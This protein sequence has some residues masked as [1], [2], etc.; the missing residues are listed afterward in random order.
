MRIL[1]ILDHSI[2]LHTGYAL[3]TQMILRAQ[4][5]LGWETF[6]LSG[7]K[8]GA[9]AADH[10]TVDGWD[11]HRTVPPGGLFEGVA[12]LSE[13]EL[14]GEIAHRIEQIVKKVRPHILH[15]HSPVLNAIPA[16]RVGRR[17]NIPVVYEVRAIWE[18]A[19]VARGTSRAG[20][21]FYRLRRA[22]ETWA[23]KRADAVT[24]LCEGLR[25]DIVA[26]GIP[27]AKV[28]VVP[29]AIETAEFPAERV[30][31]PVLK[32]Q[33]GIDGFPVLGYIGSI[34]AYEG[35]DLLLQALPQIK[36]RHGEVRVLIVGDG[37]QEGHLRNLAT[38][39]GVAN[40]VV[41]GGRVWHTDLP[42]LSDLIDVKVFPR[43][44]VRLTE[45][46]A[47]LKVLEAMAQGSVLAASDVGGI[48][49]MIRHDVSGVLFRPGD[50]AAL[51]SAVTDLL[52]A[53]ERCASIGEAAR[54]FVKIERNPAQI[55]ARYADVY[56]K[57]LQ[58]APRK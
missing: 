10:E 11:F 25:G 51:A 30:I 24:T 13:I 58:R 45:L 19:A 18:D 23:L 40:Q 2:P 32:G 7:P 5:D 44:S 35:L 27:A 28:T 48:R 15:A 37:P 46:V 49:E 22:L 34:N 12:G 53:P 20:S 43:L 31:D 36:A 21:L 50:P 47:P 14:M 39:L 29:N 38:A 4:R 52:G 8:Q 6:H 1:H 3:R 56:S 33:L 17:L 42:R 57:V 41:F 55:V 26:R 16:L 54:A 9:V